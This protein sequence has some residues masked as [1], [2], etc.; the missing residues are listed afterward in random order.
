MNNTLPNSVITTQNGKTLHG[1]DI[2][3]QK[4]AETLYIEIFETSHQPKTKK[5]YDKIIGELNTFELKELFA[6]INNYLSSKNK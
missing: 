1:H 2:K 4:E 5:D 3:Q 6:H